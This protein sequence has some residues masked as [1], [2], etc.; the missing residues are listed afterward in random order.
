MLQVECNFETRFLHPFTM[1]L[2]GSSGSGKTYFTKQLIVD[3]VKPSLE[4]L[5]WF[6]SEWQEGYG[7]MPSN[8]NMIPG[9]PKSLDKY[10]DAD[11]GGPKAFMFDDLMTECVDNIMIA[12]AFT[13]KR[14]HRDVS[15]IL[16]VQNLF[17]QGKAMRT[18]HLNT[19]YVVLFGNV[20]DKSQFQHFARQ[21]EPTNS[22]RLMDAH[23]DATNTTYSHLLVDLKPLTPN[24]LRYRSDSLSND[25]Q[26]VYSIG[27]V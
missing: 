9:M 13:K 14:H 25:A 15:V 23:V 22:K 20:R 11:P 26:I 3:R 21:I 27:G 10:L 4:A 12:E 6:Y 17:C 8:V 5:F 19:E 1:L 7:D 18:V 2:A 24:Q 16:L